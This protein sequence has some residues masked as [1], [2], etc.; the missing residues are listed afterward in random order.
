MKNTLLIVLLVSGFSLFGQKEQLRIT[1]VGNM[2]VLI[3]GQEHSLLI[4]GLHDEYK[5]AYQFPPE[6]LV[7]KMTK[8]EQINPPIRLVLNT[9]IH[10][11]H[12]DNQLVADFLEANEEAYFLGPDQAIQEVS[13]LYP[14]QKRMV[15]IKTQKHG[16]QEAPN[17]YLKITA[18]YL[19]HANPRMHN[20]TKNVG[21]LIKVD[22]KNIVHF[23]DAFWMEEVFEKLDLEKEGID[24]A[25]M[26]AWMIASA[27]NRKLIDRYL[28]PKKIIATHISPS[29]PQTMDMLQEFYPEAIAFTKIL[30]EFIY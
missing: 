10:Q 9:H 26:P 7:E 29:Y 14:I 27:E 28:Q 15:G 3:S 19:N 11:D 5:P 16:R 23:G 24:I 21:Y 12:F 1:Y 2:G 30:Q 4:D 6:E 13:Q 8:N 22:G 25:I 18:F 20:K 17:P